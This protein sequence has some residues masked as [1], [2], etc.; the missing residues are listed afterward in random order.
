MLVN[1][2]GGGAARVAAAV[3]LSAGLLFPAAVA[4][5]VPTS[6][7][8]GAETAPPSGSAATDGGNSS[9]TFGMAT[10]SGGHVDSRGFLQLS[11]TP[12]ATV[13]DNVAI[14]NISQVPL[15]LEVYA[16]DATNG[17]D[18]SLQGGLKADTSRLVGTWIQLGASTVTLPPQTPGVGPGMQV[19]PVTITIPADA[20]PGD[21]VGYIFTSLTATG[22]ASD[23]PSLNLEQ[24]VGVRVYVT[25]EGQVRAGLTVT[26]VQAHFLPGTGAGAGPGSLEVEYTLTNTGNVRYGV[27][28]SV[29]AAGPFGLTPRSVDGPV[30]EQLLPHASVRQTMTLAGVSPLFFENVTVSA[31]AVPA[32]GAEEPGIGTVHASAWA[33]VWSWIYVLVVVLVAAVAGWVVHHRRRKRPGT[34]GP[35][36]GLWTGGDAA[37]SQT[38]PPHA[39]SAPER[40]R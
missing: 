13:Y 17:A 19:L 35:P 9:V 8:L 25:V 28:P 12:G 11:A 36:E 10:A 14:V 32:P 2:H 18:G 37:T 40:A 16:A 20:E 15:A 4:S 31:T 39:P 21:H 6:G 7:S 23:T 33:W 30:I 5:A 22:Q 27:E 3:A 24:R 38:T 34:W 29:R 26:G 1:R